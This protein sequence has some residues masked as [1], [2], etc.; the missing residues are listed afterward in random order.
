[1]A[2]KY[3]WEGGEKPPIQ[4]G[5]KPNDS[6]G[7]KIETVFL[8]FA[9]RVILWAL[10]FI[11]DRLVDVFDQSMKILRPGMERATVGVFPHLKQIK[12]MPSFFYQMMDAI[13]KEQGETSF[14]TKLIVMYATVRGIIFGGLQPYADL[15]NQYALNQVRTWIPDV[16][17]TSFLYRIGQIDATA[18]NN[19]LGGLGVPD[20]LKPR[21]LELSRNLPTTGESIAGLWRNVYTEQEFRDL[22][23][24]SGHDPKDIELYIELSKN[25]PP[26]SDLIRFLVRDAFNDDASRRYG[27]DEDFPQE[28]NEHFA[29]QG[30][31][32]D[33][34]KRYWRA[35]WDLPSPTQAYEMLHRGLIDRGDLLT[36]L[37]IAD[38]P[39]FWR[40][41]LEKISYNVLTRVD[42]RRLLQSGLIDRAKALEVY[43]AMGYTPED[44][45]LLTQFAERGITQDE[46]D[47]T[48]TDVLN[49]YEEGLTDRGVTADNLIKMGY[50]S[51]EAESILQ[52]SDV[53][54]AKSAR[55]DLINYTKERFLAR[56]V[57]EPEARRELSEI[58]LRVQ[59]VDRYIL[60]WQRATEIEDNLPSVSDAKRWYLGD[61]INEQQLREYLKLHRHTDANIA[62][63][64]R[65]LNDKKAEGASEQA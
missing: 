56:K 20:G 28:I 17:T 41:K 6:L 32:P 40:E 22:L 64:V 45:E 13:E 16:A 43:K 61:Y 34:A 39:P 37:K 2:G 52:L 31:N 36:L 59:S 21:M 14:F 35:H 38:Y 62:L 53:A 65:E 47:L 15:A 25:I 51:Q 11:S 9:Q 50:D 19:I 33:W 63:Y 58:G 55:T 5:W 8:R 49:L 42:V 60:N 18:Y 23:K 29:R 54:I 44:A 24:R 3:R 12:G 10:D 57:D 1:M 48:K 26:L 7:V 27:Y 30:F 46:R 4:Q